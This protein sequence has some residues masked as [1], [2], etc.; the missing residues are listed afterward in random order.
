MEEREQQALDHIKRLL[1]DNTIPKLEGSL[2]ENPVLQ[3]IHTDLKA[4]REVVY[5]FSSG[6]L[7]P[8]IKVRGIIPGCLKSLQAHLRHMIWQVKMVEQGDFNQRV[9]F[10]G[11]FSTAFNNMVCQLDTTLNMLKRKE[12]ALTALTNNLRNEVDLRNSAVE[13][14]QESESRFKFLASHD[15][16]TGALNRRSFIDRAMAELSVAVERRVPCCMV[17]MDIDHFKHFNDTYGH[18]A[19]D[20]ALRHT[21]SIMAASLRK[22]D[23]MGRYGGEEFIFLF[24]NADRSTGI[25]IAERIRE[26]LAASPVKIDGGQIPLT[27]SF[28]VAEAMDEGGPPDE[29]YIRQL[30]SNADKALYEAKKAGRN[31]VVFFEPAVSPLK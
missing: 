5:A 19:G 11:E 18:L 27:A 13:A 30:I 20:E 28:G 12:E 8:E 17:I 7:S 1:K 23:F 14:L 3:E 6:D 2:A 24:N 22:P 25:A 10:M 15:P 4:I 26:A 16:L 29:N 9:Q 31:R 21:V